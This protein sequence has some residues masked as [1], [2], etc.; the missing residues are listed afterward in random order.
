VEQVEVGLCGRHT[1]TSQFSTHALRLL[2]SRLPASS[3]CGIANTAFLCTP[4]LSLPAADQG[5]EGRVPLLGVQVRPGRLRPHSERPQGVCRGGRHIGTL[6]HQRVRVG[7]CVGG[8]ISGMGWDGWGAREVEGAR[9]ASWWW[10][11]PCACAPA[12]APVRTLFATALAPT[13]LNPSCMVVLFVFPP[14]RFHPAGWPRCLTASCRSWWLM[15]RRAGSCWQRGAEA[16][17]EGRCAVASEVC[18]R[19]KV[20]LTERC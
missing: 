5:P 6:C 1:F 13:F 17:A 3:A 14:T 20:R 7:V 11:R 12:C 9:L 19:H 4:P 10:G 8:E 16:E 18:W 15:C 2:P